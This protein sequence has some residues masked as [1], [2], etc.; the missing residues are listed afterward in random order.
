MA[1]TF[2]INTASFLSLDPS[3]KSKTEQASSELAD[4]NGALLK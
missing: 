4:L 2:L 1:L 3:P